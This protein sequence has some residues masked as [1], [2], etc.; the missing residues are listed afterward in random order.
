MNRISLLR[1]TGALICVCMLAGSLAGCSG[2]KA[3]TDTTDGSEEY[4]MIIED[5]DLDELAE[6]E[7]IDPEPHYAKAMTLMQIPILRRP[8]P[9]F[10]ICL[11]RVR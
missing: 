2:S 7:E 5:I 8:A 10:P 6:T 9:V 4:L 11:W 3:P 1:R